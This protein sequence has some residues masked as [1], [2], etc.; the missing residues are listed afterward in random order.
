MTIKRRLENLEKRTAKL[1]EPTPEQVSQAM[2]HHAETGAWPP[3]A[4]PQT[5]ALA[6]MMEAASREIMGAV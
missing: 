5:I 6:E 3:D 1:E 2:Q 4:S